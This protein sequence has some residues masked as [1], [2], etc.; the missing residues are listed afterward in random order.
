MNPDQA[1]W[2][3]VRDEIDSVLAQISPS[4]M[5]DATAMLAGPDRRWFCTGQGRSG[6]VVQMA[7]MRLMH[8]GLDAHVVGETTAPSIADGDGLLVV[9]RSGETPVTVHLVGLARAAGAQ[10]LTVTS[11]RDSTLGRIADTVIHVPTD[12][13]G[14]FGGTLFEQS[15]LLLL[16]ALIVDLTGATS[17]A[18]DLMAERHTNLQ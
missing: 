4:Q 7:A 8:I 18:Y 3:G 9:S 6:L 1:S 10:I 11:H 15:A 14:Q 16:D 17:E 13:T 5:R 2:I 12:H